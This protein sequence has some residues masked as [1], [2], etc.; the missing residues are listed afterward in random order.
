MKLVEL[1]AKELKEWPAGARYYTQDYNGKAFPYTKKPALA[2]SESNHL[3]S[4]NGQLPGCGHVSCELSTDHATA[5]VT[6]AD[7]QAA[8][9]K[10]KPAAKAKGDG[11]IRHRGGKCPVQSG[12]LVDVRCR[13]GRILLGKFCDN[14]RWDHAAKE[15]GD[16]MGYRVC[17]AQPA[18]VEAIEVGMA[19]ADAGQL[20]PIADVKAGFK[21]PSAKTRR[22]L[23]HA[24][25]L[26]EGAEQAKRI[27][28]A[29]VGEYDPQPVSE[30]LLE[31]AAA[32]STDDELT[33]EEFEKLM[34]SPM[35]WRDQVEFID[36][37]LVRLA[38]WRESLISKLAAEGF[39]LIE[40]VSAK[41]AECAVRHDKVSNI[42]W[43]KAPEGT[44]HYQPDDGSEWDA[45]WIKKGDGDRLEGWLDDGIYISWG[46]AGLYSEK[47]NFLIERPSNQ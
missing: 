20:T 6:R 29:L 21:E 16:V 30:E 13:D 31:K 36:S 40:R 27:Y 33:S 34:N 18:S 32:Y 44:T 35:H 19:A 10:L 22:A 39:A 17:D 2:R 25:K 41:I 38:T 15:D 1:L 45:S 42:D 24:K 3:W 47:K 46:Y 23:R 5:I 14:I 7:W 43:S 9:A 8:R 37:E 12:A 28:D 11:F 26:R 4:A